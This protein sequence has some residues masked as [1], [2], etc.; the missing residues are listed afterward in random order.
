MQGD[1]R[2]P[3]AMAAIGGRSLL[4]SFDLEDYN[5]LIDRDRCQADWDRRGFGLER[6][7]A[8]VSSLLDELDA[9]ATFFC[10]GVTAPHYPDLV[11]A[12]VARGD[13]VACHGYVH[14]PVFSQTRDG[15]RA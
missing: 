6:Q 11:R 15:F 1:S 9:H 4:L 13:E 5:Q 14:K 12:I 2:V 3:C 10:L 7:V 8:A